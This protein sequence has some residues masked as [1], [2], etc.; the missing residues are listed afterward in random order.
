M[1]LS[2]LLLLGAAGVFHVLSRDA[3]RAF[4]RRIAALLPRTVQ[5]DHLAVLLRDFPEQLPAVRSAALPMFGLHVIWNT[6]ACAVVVA[7]IWFSPP[8]ALS[9]HAL[10]WL[11]ISSIALVPLA[12]LWDCLAFARVWKQTFAQPVDGDDF[13]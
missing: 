1:S 13:S 10:E 4:S 9:Q 2:F 11:R 3:K 7:G 6:A 5:T 12:F 8:E